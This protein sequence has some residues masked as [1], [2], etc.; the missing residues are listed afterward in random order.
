MDYSEMTNAI[1]ETIAKVETPLTDDQRMVLAGSLS[2]HVDKA[3]KEQD[4]RTRHACA[5]AVLS[6]PE[7]M[8]AS[9]LKNCAHRHCMN[10][11]AL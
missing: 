10:A 11:R 9:D 5:A 1:C 3:I 4:A 6:C 2:V 7:D 8:S